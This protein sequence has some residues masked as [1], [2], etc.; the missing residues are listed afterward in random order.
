M[1]RIVLLVATAVLAAVAEDRGAA[2]PEFIWRDVPALKW[3][4]HGNARIEG[5]TL[6]C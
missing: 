2:A 3:R 1:K 4:T 5:D 6:T